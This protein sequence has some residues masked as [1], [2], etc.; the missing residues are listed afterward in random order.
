MRSRECRM[1]T[2]EMVLPQR[3]NSTMKG[4]TIRY[5]WPDSAGRERDGLM[6][7]HANEGLTE[8]AKTIGICEQKKTIGGFTFGQ[9]ALQLGHFLRFLLLA[10]ACDVVAV[11][12]W[13]SSEYGSGQERLAADA[14]LPHCWQLMGGGWSEG[15]GWPQGAL[16]NMQIGAMNDKRKE[17]LL[18]LLWRL[19]DETG[20]RRRRMDGRKEGRMF[21]WETKR[22]M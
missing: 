11:D 13:R 18:L 22:Q 10:D 20:G 1:A 19:M 4:S 9:N 3:P 6:W 15:A 12:E 5:S 21:F 8:M 16:I 7:C 17:G 14:F 2:S